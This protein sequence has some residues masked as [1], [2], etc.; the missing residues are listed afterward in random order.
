MNSAQKTFNI[1]RMNEPS[2]ERFDIFAY[3]IHIS[4]III[5][6]LERKIFTL[7]SQLSSSDSVNILFKI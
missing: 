2:N 6:E 1:A 5:K 7:V 3:A 4:F